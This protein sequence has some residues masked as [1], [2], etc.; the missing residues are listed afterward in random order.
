MDASKILIGDTIVCNTKYGISP[1]LVTNIVTLD[2]CPVDI[3]VK[4]VARKEIRRNGMVVEY[5][6]NKE[7]LKQ[8]FIEEIKGFVMSD[9]LNDLSG[10]EIANIYNL[11]NSYLSK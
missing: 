5:Q 3:P 2:K 10:Q 1:V 7:E 8:E 11:M 6:M 4:R 9:R